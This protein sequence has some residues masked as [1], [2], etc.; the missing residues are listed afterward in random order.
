MKPQLFLIYAICVGWRLYG[1]RSLSRIPMFHGRE[2]F[3]DVLVGEDFYG[4]LGAAVL[5]EYRL[6]LLIPYGIEAMIAALFFAIGKPFW[7]FLLQVPAAILAGFYVTGL[8]RR[9]A[10]RA[11][12]FSIDQDAQPL[13]LTASL[14]PRTAT[15]YRRP[16]L[17]RTLNGLTILAL[18]ALAWAI[19]RHPLDWAELLGPTF[20][21]YAQLGVRLA[22]RSVIDWRV[23]PVPAEGAQQV[24]AWHDEARRLLLAMFD[25]IR[26]FSV[27]LLSWMSIMPL[28]A[29]SWALWR[30]RDF[31][32]GWPLMGI[33]LLMMV[34]LHRRR[35]RY[36]DSA[37]VLRNAGLRPAPLEPLPDG[38][39]L[40]YR[41]E[42]PSAIIRTS[43][44]YALNAANPR[45]QMYFAYAAGWVALIVTTTRG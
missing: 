9:F 2:W 4:G 28:A 17:D 6:R 13:R 42:H 5:R 35:R 11:W 40:C 3:F 25:W 19:S 23:S 15:G 1:L 10:K 34:D 27:Y 22:K 33:W 31:T 26:I 44:G 36:V 16:M 7:A 29:E 45:T 12:A 8:A 39:L 24:L 14:V 18:A 38:R 30:Y 37:R 43:R 21:L 32:L 41:R 20:V